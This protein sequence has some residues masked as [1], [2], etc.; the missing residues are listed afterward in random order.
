VALRAQRTSTNPSLLIHQ[1][2]PLR[3]HQNSPT[4]GGGIMIS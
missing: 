1:I 4:K 3:P 2:K